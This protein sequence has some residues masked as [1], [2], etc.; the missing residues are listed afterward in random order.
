MSAA[1][2]SPGALAAAPAKLTLAQR[3]DAYERLLR[4]HRPIGTLLLL[5]PTLSA[6][7]IASYGRP[8]L[9]MVLVFAV[10]T[11]VMR[12]AG[13][14][15]NDWADRNYD[16]HVKRTADRPL[17]RGEIA[18]WEALVLGSALSLLAFLLVVL[19][20]NRTTILLSVAAFA[21]A[22]AYPFCKRFLALP[23]AFLGVA[24]S[25]GIPMAFA[26]VLGYVSAFG[27]WLFAFNLFWVIAY[28]TEYAMVDRD[29][30]LRIGIRTSAITFGRFDILAV[31]ICYA[32]FL[33]GMAWLAW[34]IP[35]GLL[36]WAGFAA[37]VLL[38]AHHLWLIRHRERDACFR[39][40]LNN[41]WLGFALFAGIAAD[42]AYR[43]KAWPRLAG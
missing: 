5:W 40:F 4:L 14:A 16:A 32:I 39:A 15:F 30:D 38:A 2:P 34:R 23:Q 36:F 26:A 1:D 20:T 41:H 7:W 19:A 33:G 35:L 6:L 42:Y 13:C 25:F 22:V 24:F 8:T 9:I 27:W 43:L 17:A 18:P 21:I 28:D 10:G 12:S 31:G 29:D 37:A 3:L 11:L